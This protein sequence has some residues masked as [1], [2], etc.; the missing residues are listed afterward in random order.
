M[1]ENQN[2]IHQPVSVTCYSGRS[3]ADRPASF[4]WQ[5]RKYEVKDIE[6]GWLEPGQRHFLVKTEDDRRFEICYHEPE[7]SWSLVEL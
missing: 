5:G 6:R 1:S 2:I 7:D 3:F 4:V